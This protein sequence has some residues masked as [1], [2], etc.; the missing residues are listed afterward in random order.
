MI[1]HIESLP[2]ELIVHI[3]S[4]LK[5]SDIITCAA[6]SRRFRRV[7]SDP[8]LN[9]WRQYVIQ[10]FST[11]LAWSLTSGRPLQ[12]LLNYESYS[13]ELNS[14]SAW[15]SIIPIQNWIDLLSR[16]DPRFLLYESSLP[17]L[18]ESH[19]EEAFRRRYLPGWTKWKRNSSWKTCFRR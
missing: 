17:P 10:A 6:L 12:Q 15:S 9:P 5:I 2:V 7:I 3:I 11:Q 1:S 13:T 4:Q 19:W 8:S 18:R 14:L 16:A